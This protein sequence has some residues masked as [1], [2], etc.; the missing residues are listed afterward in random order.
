MTC[1]QPTGK[2]CRTSRELNQLNARICEKTCGNDLNDENFACI[3]ARKKPVNR[4]ES[5][6]E[7]IGRV[8]IDCLASTLYLD[9]LLFTFP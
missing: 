7:K 8:Q 1:V 4:K 2:R 5:G 6:R 9:D 3:G